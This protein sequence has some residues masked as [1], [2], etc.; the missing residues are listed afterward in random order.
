MTVWK[1]NVLIGITLI[2]YFF[3]GILRWN[4]IINPWIFDG[5]FLLYRY[6]AVSQQNFNQNFSDPIRYFL[7][8]PKWLSTLIYG[9][10][11]LALNI[12]IIYLVHQKRVYVNFTFWLFFWVSVISVSS[13]AFG[14]LTKTYSYIYP[15][16]SEVKELQQSP[17]TLML[18]LGAFKL[19]ERGV[20]TKKEEK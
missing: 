6:S 15:I 5:D 4:Y 20:E 19:N 9:N 3:F 2:V 14:F 10:V 16:V 1:R 8:T 18:L 11:F 13:L 7:F 17:F 12:V